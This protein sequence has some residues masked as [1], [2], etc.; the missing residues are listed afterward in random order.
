MKGDEPAECSGQQ[1]EAVQHLR[2]PKPHSRRHPRPRL[3]L[4]LLAWKF[5][6][7]HS[8]AWILP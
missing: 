6:L 7:Q 2:H 5:L 8:W 3:L 1:T 4:Q